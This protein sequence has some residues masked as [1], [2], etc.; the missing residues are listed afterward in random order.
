MFREEMFIRSGNP[1]SKDTLRRRL[2]MNERTIESRSND[3]IVASKREASVNWLVTQI[4]AGSGRSLR[5]RTSTPQFR[6]PELPHVPAH[7]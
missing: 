4:G 1:L 7:T 3:W 6:S 5:K 2:W